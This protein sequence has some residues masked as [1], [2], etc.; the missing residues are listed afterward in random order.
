VDI[1]FSNKKLRRL[2]ND[3]RKCQKELG[4]IRATLFNKRL[5]NLS[6][7]DTLED[8]RHL[9]GRYH[10]LIGNRKGQWACDLDQPYR[11]IFEPHEDPIPQDSNGKYLWIEIKG[12][13][14]LEIT[15]YHSK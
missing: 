1:T 8:V 10:E 2:A 15:N 6:N 14:I 7:A 13:E 9:P 5:G 3:Y 11:L 4:Q 12:V